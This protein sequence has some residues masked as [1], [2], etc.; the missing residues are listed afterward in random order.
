MVLT[1]EKI[2]ECAMGQI[3]EEVD[4][5]LSMMEDDG[6]TDEYKNNCM[7]AWLAL[8]KMQGVINLRNSLLNELDDAEDIENTK[9]EKLKKC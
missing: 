1:K 9:E 4:C 3:I 2:N 8:A 6:S 5:Q 7:Y